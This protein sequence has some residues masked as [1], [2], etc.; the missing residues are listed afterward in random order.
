MFGF[1]KDIY[2]RGIMPEKKKIY[3]LLK[4]YILIV[5]GCALIAVAMD[6]FLV[7]NRIASGGATGFATVV[8]HLTGGRLPVGAVIIA[9]NIPLFLLGMK[10]MGRVFLIRSAV[11]TV[12]LSVM[13]ELFSPYASDFTVKYLSDLPTSGIKTDLLL[14][15]IFGG[16][17]MGLGIGLVFRTDGT[18]GGT[19][20]AAALLHK[21]F[22]N[23]TIGQI[24]LI[25]DGLIVL[26]AAIAFKSF[27][28]GM[29]AIVVIYITAKI[30]DTILEG[31]NFA[32]AV[33]IISDYPEEISDLI[34]KKL[35]RGVTALD[36][37]GMYTK[38]EKKVLF[39]VLER[40]QIP[41]LKIIVKGQDPNAFIV[42]T[43]IREVLGEFRRGKK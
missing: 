3:N 27:L 18:T 16:V 20:I 38:R 34:L 11:S 2:D 25:I 12:L 6:V 40:T 5:I 41:R 36:G 1:S 26:M 37:T 35:D 14:F 29:Y 4:D 21:V 32:K 28:L 43:D 17:L 23:I 8:F 9:V 13:I 24:I 22:P 19:D 30:I 15:C 31:V 42:M 39:C 33:Y 10:V 7:P